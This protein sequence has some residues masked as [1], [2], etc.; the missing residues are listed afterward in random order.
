MIID[1]SDGRLDQI[2]A[3][4]KENDLMESFTETFARLETYSDKGYDVFL[5]SDFA[6]LS[7]E[8]VIQQAERFVLNGGFIFHGTHDGWGNGGPPT[9]SVSLSTEK[10]I[11]WSI[12]T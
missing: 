6:P 7:L 4:A 10:K 1:K 11:G 2:R 9:F 5:F 12:H 8:F 3:F